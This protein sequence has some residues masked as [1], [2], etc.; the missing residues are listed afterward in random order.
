MST[1][2]HFNC[3]FI[4]DVGSYY[5]TG[6][7]YTF[8][9]NLL[10]QLLS[11][12]YL[13]VTAVVYQSRR[14]QE[15][16]DG[17]MR[18][19]TQGL[20][21]YYVINASSYGIGTPAVDIC[22]ALALKTL[23]RKMG[24][25]DLLVFDQPNPVQHLFKN[26]PSIAMFHG[27]GFSKQTFSLRH[28]RSSLHRVWSNSL[29]SNT[30]KRYLTDICG[31]VPMFNSDDTLEKLSEDF[32]LSKVD[33]NNLESN[34]TWLPIDTE[35]FKKDLG[36]RSS[37][38]S[39]YKILDDEVVIIYLSNFNSE[40][41]RACLAPI[42]FGKIVQQPK[43]RIFF[44]G[45]GNDDYAQPLDAF[46]RLHKNAQRIKEIPLSDAPAWFN[47]ADIAVSFSYRETFGYTVVEG[48]A[49]E[50][51]TVVF[52]LGALKEHIV[53]GVNGLSVS[54]NQEFSESLL[55]LAT[56]SELRKEYGA[57]ARKT[58]LDRYSYSAFG[59]RFRLLINRALS[60]SEPSRNASK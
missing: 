32:S 54:G 7:G 13:L 3:L 39:K 15:T 19:I 30:Y 38:R 18:T 42:L 14:D 58:V 60:C 25:I 9:R 33:R 12:E 40:M 8:A 34:V 26:I 10:E 55:A 4:G 37:M 52:S 43:V 17:L 11:I 27:G 35:K 28:P 36:I 47:L 31:Y 49:C 1:D 41:K 16:V 53:N 23:I 2:R 5:R 50:L 24:R 48:M 45:A 56:N 57:A 29:L 51:P 22:A 59:Q 6:G 46:C 44:V 21:P 20:T